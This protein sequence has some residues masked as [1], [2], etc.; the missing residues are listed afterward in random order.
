MEAGARWVR[1]PMSLIHKKKIIYMKIIIIA[2][3]K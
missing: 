2:S 1:P 3:E